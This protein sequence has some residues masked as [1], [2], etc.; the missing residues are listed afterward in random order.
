M[1]DIDTTLAKFQL[2]QF[3]DS[4]DNL[5]AI[6]V[7][8]LAERFKLTQQ[9]GKLKAQ[10]NL[11]P[12][13]KTREAEQIER[14]RQM[15]QESGLDPAFAEKFLNFIVAEVIRHHEHIRGLEAD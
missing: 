14:L 11:P 6:L 15:A 4:I 8:T 1:T 7:H 13:D 5:D 12:A 9:V 2:N 10:H 3:R